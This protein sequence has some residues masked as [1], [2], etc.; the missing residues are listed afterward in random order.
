MEQRPLLFFPT[1][2]IVG[3]SKL[4]KG[5]G[6]YKTPSAERQGQR[7]SPKF[8]SFF[9]ALE[10]NRISAQQST[11]GLDP[12]QVLVLETIGS[13]DDFY[14]AVSKIDGFDWL[15]EVDIY[16]IEPDDEFYSLNNDGSRSEKKM[17]GRVYFI[18]TNRTAMSNLL[19][20]W[21]L[22]LRDPDFSCSS[23]KYRGR[24]KFKEVFKLLKDIRAWGAKDRF[25]ESNILDYWE[26]SIE[27]DPSRNVKF[28]IELWYRS[29]RMQRATSYASVSRIIR[30]L[31]GRVIT[32]CD[33]E[34]IRYHAVLAELPAIEI[35]KI[36]EH[37]DTELVQCE[38]IMFF[39]P[40]GQIFIDNNYSEEDLQPLE[41]IENNS[42]P[43]GDPIVAILDGYPMVGH[44]VLNKRLVIDDPDDFEDYYQVDDRKHGTAMCSLIVRGDLSNDE[45]PISTP[46]YVRPIMRP[47]HTDTNRREFVPDNTLLIDTVHRAVKR[48]FEGERDLKPV[49]P[50]VKIINFSIGDPNRTFYNSMSP[51]GKL[52]DWLSYKYRVVFIVSAGNYTNEIE[53]DLTQSE[54][55]NLSP[56]EQEKIFFESIVNNS[57][58]S[59]LM[60][61]AESI[62]NLTVGALHYD[63]SE[64]RQHEN[65]LNPYIALLPSTYT[66]FGGGYRRA[67]KPDLVYYGGRQM[68]R[69]SYNSNS[70]ITPSTFNIEPGIKVAAPDSTRTKA[71]HVIGTSNSAALI[72]RYGH[73]CY[74]VIEE[75]ISENNESIP[76]NMK[77]VLIKAMLTHGCSWTD[78]EDNLE[79]HS[80]NF[81]AS[82]FEKIKSN[83]IGYGLPNI[84]KVIEC[85]AQ[86]ATVVGF[87]GL[88]EDEA[89][90]Y[91][92]PI[93]PSLSSVTLKR[94][95][96][97]TLSW[98]T[99]ISPSTQKYRTARLWF[100]AKNKLAYNRINND[101]RAVR[102]GTLQHEVF[103]GDRANAFFD[104]DSIK[105]KVN[106]TR[107]A[108]SFEDKIPYAIMVTL[109]VAE[110][111]GVLVYQEVKER[112]S[113]P[114]RVG[115][116]ISI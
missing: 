45:K 6:E 90:V 27:I 95:L 67:V 20:L 65:R 58:N 13:V 14:K 71:I 55:A 79:N 19:S 92:L 68:Y 80:D 30:D 25:E 33:I 96:T 41:H 107:D 29:K 102:R 85:T 9:D 111:S 91:R 17:S 104:G 50:H 2:D 8:Q 1:K 110:G 51:L 24:S 72:S 83:M 108:G 82:Q 54:F 52:L 116:P 70:T 39:K 81:E 49:A 105:I 11:D 77:S 43:L 32:T 93:P 106:C 26:E 78:I 56:I 5:R 69:F 94:R 74:E 86:R 44:E 84:N 38:S 48:I 62:N 60:S 3:R 88:R 40:S 53:T 42:Y 7:L 16:D 37:E 103:E 46:L 36:L 15:G 12:E 100:E 47:D 28:E 57:R 73:H 31:G 113:T 112:I 64:L 23:G 63:N 18:F 89:H 87:G 4:P 22:W 35:A 66:A 21:S 114:V 97:V 61:P 34:A 10:A 75:L 115:Q 109:E 99:P 76:T 98:F 59:R 101:W